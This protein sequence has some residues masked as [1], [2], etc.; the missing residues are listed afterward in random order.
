L[1]LFFKKELLPP[2]GLE[3]PKCIRNASHAASAVHR[4]DVKADACAS[5]LR[6]F[7]EQNFRGASQPCLLPRPQRGGSIGQFPPCLY[8]NEYRQAIAFRDRINFPCRGAHAA[9]KDTEAVPGQRVAC[10]LFRHAASFEMCH[11][12]ILFEAKERFAFGA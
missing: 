2:I 4:H 1:V 9:P 7:A 11:P 6:I 10:E 5:P 8:F 12:T 3:L